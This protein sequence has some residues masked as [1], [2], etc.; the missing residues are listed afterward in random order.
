MINLGLLVVSSSPAIVVAM[1]FEMFVIAELASCIL[2]TGP[3]RMESEEHTE[4]TE[5]ELPEETDE[6]TEWSLRFS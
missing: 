2:R 3:E 6:G 5:R 4:P 1:S